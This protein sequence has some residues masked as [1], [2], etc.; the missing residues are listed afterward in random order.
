MNKIVFRSKRWICTLY[1]K[2]FRLKL[3]NRIPPIIIYFK[4][5]TDA[6]LAVTILENLKEEEYKILEEN[7]FKEYL[8]FQE[9]Y[10]IVFSIVTKR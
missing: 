5:L 4:V 8:N 6:E 1:H 2:L 7:E 9:L 10:E 3:E